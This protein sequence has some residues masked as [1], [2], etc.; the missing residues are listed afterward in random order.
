MWIDN[1]QWRCGARDREWSFLS[2]EVTENAAKI[3]SYGK[4]LQFIAFTWLWINITTHSNN[5]SFFLISYSKQAENKRT[6]NHM[7]TSYDIQASPTLSRRPPLKNTSDMFQI[8]ENRKW[9]TRLVQSIIFIFNDRKKGSQV[10]SVQWQI[11]PLELG[12]IN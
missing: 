2:E 11:T 5:F 3:V 9:V 6:L 7:A 1:D 8:M 4:G 12:K 10:R